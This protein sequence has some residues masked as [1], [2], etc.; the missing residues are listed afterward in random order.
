MIVGGFSILVVVATV[1]S[2][3]PDEIRSAISVEGARVL[4]K[5]DNVDAIVCVRSLPWSPFLIPC[6]F[7]LRNASKYASLYSTAAFFG[8]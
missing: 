4:V 3:A 5:I 1:K 6:P 7:A 8:M 2:V